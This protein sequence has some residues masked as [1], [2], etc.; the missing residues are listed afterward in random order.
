[1]YNIIYMINK[2]LDKIGYLIVMAC[3]YA[4][5]L[6]VPIGAIIVAAYCFIQFKKM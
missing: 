5:L 2:I 6:M 1:M 3:T 4:S